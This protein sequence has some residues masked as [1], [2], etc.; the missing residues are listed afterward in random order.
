M[1]TG[2]INIPR[3]CGIHEDIGKAMKEIYDTCR[4]DS[5]IY[6]QRMLADELHVVPCTITNWFKG[7]VRPRPDDIK[8]FCRVLNYSVSDARDTYSCIDELFKM[9]HAR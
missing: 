3:P 4:M 7:H 6:T 2:R 1:S 9:F 5:G 8:D